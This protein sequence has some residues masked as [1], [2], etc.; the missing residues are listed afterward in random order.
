MPIRYLDNDEFY[1]RII[2]RDPSGTHEV[3][4]IGQIVSDLLCDH[5]HI[6]VSTARSD[7][8]HYRTMVISAA[9]NR[10]IPH[11]VKDRSAPLSLFK[12]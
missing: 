1:L 7:H 3:Y 11:S 6:L 12:S 9:E 2:W 4:I 10:R 8:I 5:M